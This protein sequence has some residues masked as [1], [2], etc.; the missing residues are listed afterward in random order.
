MNMNKQ[1]KLF[2][3]EYILL[4]IPFL[5]ECVCMYVVLLL[6]AILRSY[7]YTFGPQFPGL[8]KTLITDGLGLRPFKIGIVQ[9]EKRLSKQML[10]VRLLH[11]NC[12]NKELSFCN[13]VRIWVGKINANL[14]WKNNAY[15]HFNLIRSKNI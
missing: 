1:S 3:S 6:F 15:F 4:Y 9:W 2:R 5:Y 7:Y 13:L 14:S 8:Q 12:P 10:Y 11:K